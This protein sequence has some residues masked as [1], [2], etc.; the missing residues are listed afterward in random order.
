MMERRQRMK[1]RKTEEKT[2]PDAG[3]EADNKED[4]YL[5]YSDSDLIY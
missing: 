1:K 3:Q 2:Q 5:E 4:S